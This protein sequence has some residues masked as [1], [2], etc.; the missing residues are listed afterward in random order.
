MK[1][2]VSVV[3][4]ESFRAGGQVSRPIKYD[5]SVLGDDARVSGVRRFYL[6]GHRSRGGR[7]GD[8]LIQSKVTVP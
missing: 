1:L 3:V 7:S 6:S 5:L 8:P 2:L 4:Y